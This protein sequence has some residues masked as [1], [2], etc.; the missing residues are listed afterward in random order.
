MRHT[1]LSHII[2]ATGSL[3]KFE[4]NPDSFE[5]QEPGSLTNKIGICK[6]SYKKKYPP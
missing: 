4:L 2:N 6:E 1:V 5:G 3:S